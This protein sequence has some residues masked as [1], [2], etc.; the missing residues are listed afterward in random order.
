MDYFKSYKK[1]GV[2]LFDINL[3]GDGTEAESGFYNIESNI[4]NQ[5]LEVAY[6]N[7]CDDLM[8]LDGKNKAA[9]DAFTTKLC[10]AVFKQNDAKYFFW[11]SN[12]INR[13]LD[14][15]SCFRKM[16][17]FDLEKDI[18]P[19]TIYSINENPDVFYFFSKG[20]SEGRLFS[21][22]FETDIRITKQAFEKL[23]PPEHGHAYFDLMSNDNFFFYEKTE[24]ALV[25]FMAD[26]DYF[27]LLF[28]WKEVI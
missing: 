12:S 22:Q 27:P 3:L 7:Y 28:F 10:E 25:F 18:L 6:P 24:D 21:N 13:V 11:P 16:R 5:L 26:K 9:I 23:L 17:S 4:P 2:I 19:N 8:Q 1:E 15:Q 14:A 20:F